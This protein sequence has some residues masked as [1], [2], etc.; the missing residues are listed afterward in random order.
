[1]LRVRA[2]IDGF[3]LY[4]GIVRANRLHWL[5][6]TTFT[7]KLNGG[8]PVDKVIYCTARV[9]STPDDPNKNQRQHAYLLAV[10]AACPNVEIIYGQFRKHDKVKPLAGCKQSPTC[11]VNVVIREEKGSDVNL[12]SRLLHDAHLGRFDRAI[13]VSGD[14]DLVEPVR[15]VRDEV[16]REVWVFNPYARESKELKAVASEY[17]AIHCS[18]LRN[19]QFPD[20]IQNTKRCYRKPDEWKKPLNPVELT[21]ISSHRCSECGHVIETGRIIPTLPD[22]PNT[23]PSNT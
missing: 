11:C 1:M 13:V 5:N 20:V 9:S 18:V 17:R 2:Y 21:I 7:E 10:T 8:F 15:L 14:S 6:L 19:S 22:I 3:N 4:H 16:K 23:H 12:A